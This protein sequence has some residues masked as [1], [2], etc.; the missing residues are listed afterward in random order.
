MLK[1]RR[2][3]VLKIRGAPKAKL[4]ADRNTKNRKSQRL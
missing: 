3:E 2:E 4:A 1:A